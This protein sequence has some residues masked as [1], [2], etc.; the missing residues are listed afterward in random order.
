[1]A[2]LAIRLAQ[3]ST[4]RDLAEYFGLALSVLQRDIKE[5]EKRWRSRS[6]DALDVWKGRLLA[7][8]D[9]TAREAWIEWNRSKADAI[10]I[11]EITE[12]VE[13]EAAAAAEHGDAITTGE[14]TRPKVMHLTERKV[15]TDAQTGDPRYL[16]VIVNARAEQAKILGAHAPAKHELGGKDGALI[17]VQMIEIVVPPADPDHIPSIETTS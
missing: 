2:E 8:H 5:V 7:S 4:H 9:E 14:P 11:V 15:T 6:L 16:T 1:M 13:D 3:G 10:S 17:Q 12:L